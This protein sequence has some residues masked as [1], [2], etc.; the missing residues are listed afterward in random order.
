MCEQIKDEVH[1]KASSLDGRLA[2]HDF[3]VESNSFKQLLVRHRRLLLSQ[4]Y[5]AVRRRGKFSL[6]N[7]CDLKQGEIELVLRIQ[8]CVGWRC[9]NL[10][11]PSWPTNLPSRTMT[12]PRTV[13]ALGRPSIS[14]PSN[15]L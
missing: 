10:P 3:G 14:Q 11:W 13:T 5:V 6:F 12:R 15:A 1:G 4:S 7:F 2:H 9:R 8:K